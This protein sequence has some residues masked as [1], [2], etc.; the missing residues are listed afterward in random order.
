M[1]QLLQYGALAIAPGIFW[2]WFFWQKD[3]FEREPARYILITYFLGAAVVLPAG[4][5]EGW[6]ATGLMPMD[7]MIIG[8]VEEAAKF[9]AVYMFVFRKSEFN[10]VM[11]GIVY[12]AAAALGF[13]SLENFLYILWY[14]P[15]VMMGRAFISTP[16][17]VLFAALWGYALGLNKMTGKGTVLAGLVSA[18][19]AHGV[20]DILTE[21]TGSLL[22]NVM[23]VILLVLFL[24]MAIAG[25]IRKS[26]ELSPFKEVA[27]SGAVVRCPVCNKY[28]PMGVR[29]CPRCGNRMKS[30]P[31]EMK[32]LK[33]GANIPAES[34]FCPNC[35]EK[36]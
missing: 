12:A 19:V 2:L 17:H 31:T 22:V 21:V 26:L 3:K 11:D 20:Y 23:L 6:L 27:E 7:M 28:V 15:V 24:Y 32:C 16:A 8:I 13:A 1:I 33:C 35:G 36:L 34:N 9:L 4:T 30:M 10:E 18:M 5:L 14:E 25:K 29:F